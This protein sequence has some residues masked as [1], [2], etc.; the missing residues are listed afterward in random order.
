LQRL[1]AAEVEWA[2]QSPGDKIDVIYNGIQK[3]QLRNDF[4]AGNF[5][6]QFANDSEKILLRRSHDLR[7]GCPA[8]C[9]SQGSVEMGVT[10]NLSLLVGKHRRSQ[11]SSLGLR[12]WDKCYFTGFMSDD[13]LDKFKPLLIALFS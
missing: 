1:Y 12:I 11:A 6:R 13:P 7:E 4:D 5:R 8:E 2:L 9:G 3:K 10:S